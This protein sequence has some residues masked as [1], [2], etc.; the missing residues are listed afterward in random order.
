MS[1]KKCPFCQQWS[2]WEQQ[3]DDRC[4]HCGN[5]LDPQASHCAQ[6]EAA[7]AH[8]K[9]ASRVRLIQLNPD[10]SLGIRLL[11]WVG[12]G[13]QLLFIALLSFFIWV[14]TIAAA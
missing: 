1:T 10:D 9:A 6:Q 14:A 8:E 3:P 5:L 13:G 4:T 12:R 7:T 2:E 11:K